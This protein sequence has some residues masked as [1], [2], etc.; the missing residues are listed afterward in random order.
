VRGGEEV[1][2]EPGTFDFLGCTIL[3]QEPGS[4]D[5]FVHLSESCHARRALSI[6]RSSI[7]G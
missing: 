4:A 7:A 6:E 1:P 2:V 3:G 5:H